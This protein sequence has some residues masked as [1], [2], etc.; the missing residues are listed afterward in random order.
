MTSPTGTVSFNKTSYAPGEIMTATVNFTD[1][2]SKSGTA[3]FNL[4]DTQG[5]VTPASATFV[6]SDPVTVAPA[7]GNDRTWIL[8]AGS[9]T[10]SQAKFTATA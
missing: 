4:T 9:L 8:V 7:S 10:A 5:N 6:V 2:D 1:A 3:T